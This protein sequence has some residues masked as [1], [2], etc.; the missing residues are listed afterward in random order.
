[1]FLGAF[2][3]VLDNG[4]RSAAPIM[5][6]SNAQRCFVATGRGWQPDHGSKVKAEDLRHYYIIKND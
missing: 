1:M 5:Q 2:S 6:R 3:Y 4:L